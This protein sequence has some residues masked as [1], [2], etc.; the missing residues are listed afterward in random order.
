[1][2]SIGRKYLLLI[3]PTYVCA[4]TKLI[5]CLP[6]PYTLYTWSK[7]NKYD[8]PFWPY[9]CADT[10]LMHCLPFP[11]TLHTW[12]KNNKYDL[13]LSIFLL[14]VN[15]LVQHVARSEAGFLT[16]LRR[17]RL[18]S[19]WLFPGRGSWGVRGEELIRL[20]SWKFKNPASGLNC[21][22][23]ITNIYLFSH[24]PLDYHFLI[25]YS[26]SLSCF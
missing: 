9:V 19:N 6:F 15:A 20:E 5:H 26:R 24:R 11:Y 7:N 3:D 2:A 21:E 16:F 17:W 4:D 1:M 10:K 8:L 23:A 14:L 13:P 22:L 25:A 12:S 18:E